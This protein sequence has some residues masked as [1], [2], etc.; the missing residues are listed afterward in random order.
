[1]QSEDDDF[2]KGAAKYKEANELRD[3]EQYR[4]ALK[5]YGDARNLLKEQLLVPLLYDMAKA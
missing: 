5:L 1:L 3:T 2:R 4:E